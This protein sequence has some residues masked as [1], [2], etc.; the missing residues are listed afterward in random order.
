MTWLLDWLLR[1]GFEPLPW[2]GHTTVLEHR[3]EGMRL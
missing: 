2:G 1:A 3:N